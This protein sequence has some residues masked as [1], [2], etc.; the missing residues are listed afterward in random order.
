MDT[1]KNQLAT[2]QM[3]KQLTF[4]DINDILNGG[5]ASVEER[6]AVVELLQEIGGASLVTYCKT[7][8][9]KVVEKHHKL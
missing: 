2:K 7:V 4:G 9:P 5:E 8:L 1:D 6:I 3:L